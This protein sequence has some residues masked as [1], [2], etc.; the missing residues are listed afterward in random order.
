MEVSAQ[1]LKDLGNLISNTKSD[2]EQHFKIIHERLETISQIP[3][4]TS[5]HEHQKFL[6]EMESMRHCIK[7]CEEV[8]EHIDRIQSTINETVSS[9]RDNVRTTQTIAELVTAHN[10]RC[11]KNNLLTTVSQ[12]K[13]WLEAP[14][15]Q[16]PLLAAKSAHAGP[17]K[18]TEKQ[19]LEA[20]LESIT[21]R[22]AYLSQAASR[23]D[24]YRTNHF[25]NVVAAK[26]SRQVVVST[27]EVPIFAKE[28]RV[29]PRGSQCLGQLPNE[30]MQQ[31]SK[32]CGQPSK[33]DSANAE[34][35]SLDFEIRHSVGKSLESGST[36]VTKFKKAN[37][38]NVANRRK[39]RPTR[40]LLT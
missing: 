14:T 6:E 38:F 19:L 17:D 28:V 10:F 31:W 37:K 39:R 36:V 24:Q 40:R 23:T 5:G 11:C 1:G 32:D 26:D 18:A 4:P 7:K 27:A 29:G 12:L 15:V 22:I 16:K 2:L 20:E 34:I 9:K 13:D 30:F 33:Q 3:E 8:S 21:Q 25:E 35:P